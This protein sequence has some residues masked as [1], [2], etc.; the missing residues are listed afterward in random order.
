VL[1]KI[2]DRLIIVVRSALSFFEHNTM[3]AAEKTAV[4]VAHLN[5]S[6]AH[7]N[8]DPTRF[9]PGSLHRRVAIAAGHR[10]E[11]QTAQTNAT[12][13]EAIRTGAIRDAKILLGVVEP[14]DKQFPENSVRVSDLLNPDAPVHGN[15][16]NV[17]EMLGMNAHAPQTEPRDTED[18]EARSAVREPLPLGVPRAVEDEYV[19]QVVEVPINGGIFTGFPNNQLYLSAEINGDGEYQLL[20][21]ND[22]LVREVTVTAQKNGK[23][24]SE[25]AL[26][27]V[28]PLREVKTG[29]GKDDKAATATIIQVRK[30]PEQKGPALK[31]WEIDAK[32]D[33]MSAENREVVETAKKLGTVVV[34]GANEDY[35]GGETLTHRDIAPGDFAKGVERT[36]ALLRKTVIDMG[37]QGYSG[38]YTKLNDGLTAVRAAAIKEPNGRKA[39]GEIDGLSPKNIR[40]HDMLDNFDPYAKFFEGMG[41]TV[42]TEGGR[43]VVDIPVPGTYTT[44]QLNDDTAEGS[45]AVVGSFSR[46]QI[47]IQRDRLE[48]VGARLHMGNNSV[49][50]TGSWVQP[51]EFGVQFT[52]PGQAA[53]RTVRVETG[54]FKWSYSPENEGESFRGRVIDST[55]A[56]ENSHQLTTRYYVDAGGVISAPVEASEE[57]E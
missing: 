38:A 18:G 24:V 17:L 56:R 54:E 22:A 39:L 57:K 8:G 35:E 41:G 9:A 51:T 2:D 13:G 53:D 19:R 33:E 34:K 43:T 37:D 40:L 7:L 52:V 46:M 21:L 14:P 44:D 29:E 23:D 5:G 48:G 12:A 31:I 42:I 6:S 11:A 25:R 27:I 28:L 1:T 49:D 20:P 55:V 3:A 30:N 45:G 50:L 15:I 4:S 10:M 32:R 36:R 47:V 26:E 16:V